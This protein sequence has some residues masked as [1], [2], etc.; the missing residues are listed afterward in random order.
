MDVEMFNQT[1]SNKD[2]YDNDCALL[3][4]Q[5]ENNEN[6]YFIHTDLNNQFHTQL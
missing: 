3:N 5:E 4:V 1:L 2:Y 6:D